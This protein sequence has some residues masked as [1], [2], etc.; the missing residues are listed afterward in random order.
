M[1]GIVQ[2]DALAALSGFAGALCLMVPLASTLVYAVPGD[3]MQKYA[4][5]LSRGDP[6]PQR[7][8]ALGSANTVLLCAADLFPKGSVR[9]HGIKTFER[10]R[11]DLAILYAASILA[12]NC[13]TLKDIFLN[14]IQNNTKL[15]YPVESVVCEAGYGFT[16]WIEHNRVIIGNREMMLRHDI[17]VPSADYEKKV[18][19]GGALRGDLPV[20]VG[21]AVRHVPRQLPADRGAARILN[22]LT[23]SGISVLVQ[24]EDF[25]VT[26]SLVANTY[27]IPQGVVKVLSQPE[28]DALNAET[29]YR[30]PARA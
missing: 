13:D 25:N 20:G 11:I 24:S 28:C 8:P 16:G 9:L 5:A 7:H 18:T 26:S 10:E 21:A 14:I 17:E 22:S 4:G 1:C 15:L 6:G 30:P 2:K 19:K 27:R 29:A 3:I 12:K 23:R